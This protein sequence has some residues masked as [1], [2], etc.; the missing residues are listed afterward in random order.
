MGRALLRTRPITNMRKEKFKGEEE[1]SCII[2]G[3]PRDIPMYS[4]CEKCKRSGAGDRL[5]RK[6]S[7]LARAGLPIGPSAPQKRQ[8]MTLGKFR[9][10]KE[11]LDNYLELYIT[12]ST[13]DPSYITLVLSRQLMN[14][15]KA[16][17]E[18]VGL[19]GYWASG[20]QD[21][22]D[23]ALSDLAISTMKKDV[24]YKEQLQRFRATREQEKRLA[25][26]K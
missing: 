20:P 4:I 6:T 15:H 19:K 12:N 25:E 3:K 18:S 17:R 13:S 9:V 22:F 26:K 5:A 14:I 8:T 24:R 21:E 10:N 2:C 7:I 23:E 11:L 16:L 1:M